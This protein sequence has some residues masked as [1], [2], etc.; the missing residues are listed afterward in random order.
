MGPPP[1]RGGGER[2]LVLGWGEPGESGLGVPGC[3]EDGLGAVVGRWG[4][5]P[6]GG[7]TRG[8]Q[9]WGGGGQ[10]G[11]TAW[12]SGG[13]GGSLW[14]LCHVPLTSP[15]CRTRRAGAAF[16]AP[17]KRRDRPRVGRSERSERS[18]QPGVSCSG[19]SPHPY[20]SEIGLPGKSLQDHAEWLAYDYP[21]G[22][23]R[24]K[25]SVVGYT[26]K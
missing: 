13:V 15:G 20:L 11:R 12:G 9:S 24:A 22:H 5:R 7:G 26:T 1:L 25:Y 23:T 17:G 3:W 19:H 6:W 18:R 16:A 14:S 4:T 10:L 21:Q 8:K 2:K